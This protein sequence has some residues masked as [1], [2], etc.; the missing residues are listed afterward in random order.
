MVGVGGGFKAEAARLLHLLPPSPP[1]C[2]VCLSPLPPAS[3]PHHGCH[4]THKRCSMLLAR[5]RCAAARWLGVGISFGC[6][7]VL[8]TIPHCAPFYVLYCYPLRVLTYWGFTCLGFCGLLPFLLSLP[9][10][11]WHCGFSLRNTS[12]LFPRCFCLLLGQFRYSFQISKIGV[13]V[14]NPRRYHT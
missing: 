9:G 1:A 5:L 6:D 10:G 3:L 12:P 2:C 13:D 4:A 11:L 7:A 8:H 14:G